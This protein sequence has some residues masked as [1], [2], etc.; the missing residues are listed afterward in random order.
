M[1]IAVLSCFWYN[2]P[3]VSP[4]KYHTYFT[5]LFCLYRQI[6]CKYILNFFA[7]NTKITKHCPDNGT[8]L[9]V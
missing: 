2:N 9:L 4:T 5:K 3:Q 1:K 7:V 8:M 6:S